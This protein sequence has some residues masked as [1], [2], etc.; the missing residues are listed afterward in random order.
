MMGMGTIGELIQVDQVIKIDR[1]FRVCAEDIT[2]FLLKGV[3]SG[4]NLAR[5]SANLYIQP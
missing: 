4:A 5:F 3:R 1:R 2:C